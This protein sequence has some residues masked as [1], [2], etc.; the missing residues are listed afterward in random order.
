MIEQWAMAELR[1]LEARLSNVIEGLQA[2]VE[3]AEARAE[4]EARAARLS[5]SPIR[6]SGLSLGAPQRKAEHKRA[7]TEEESAHE[8]AR[9]T[10]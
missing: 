4:G 9:R 7:A 3:A 10:R 2:E 5:Y 1:E 6:V 8:E